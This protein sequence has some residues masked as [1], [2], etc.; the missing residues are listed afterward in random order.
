MDRKSEFVRERERDRRERESACM[1]EHWKH[2][3]A[4]KSV[5]EDDDIVAAKMEN[6][7]GSFSFVWRLIFEIYIVNKKM[8]NANLCPNGTS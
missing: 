1:V 6:F 4:M 5:E 8:G 2:W 7:G 3:R